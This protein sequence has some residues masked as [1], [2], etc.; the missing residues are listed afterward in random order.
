MSWGQKKKRSSYYLFERNV[1]IAKI[2]DS[3][4]NVIAKAINESSV[5]ELNNQYSFQFKMYSDYIDR[6]VR[7]D[8]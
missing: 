8:F 7:G 3:D 4:V 6:L 2:I 1:G 5:S